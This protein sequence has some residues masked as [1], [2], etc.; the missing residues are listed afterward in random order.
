M[1]EAPTTGELVTKGAITDD[2]VGVAVDAYLAGDD[3]TAF[4]IAD[5]YRLNVS[6]AVDNSL[7]ANRLLARARAS[8]AS[9]RGV[10]RTAILL[11]RPVRR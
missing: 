5:G 2:D 6:I 10:V 1:S 7:V 3:T 8:A 4:A 11:A 9:R